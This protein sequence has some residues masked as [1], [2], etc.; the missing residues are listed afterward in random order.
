MALVR[1]DC[2]HTKGHSSPLQLSE[3]FCEMR[4]ERRPKPVTQTAFPG[5]HTK[6]R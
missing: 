1:R 6:G 2:E 5:A 4:T 3:P